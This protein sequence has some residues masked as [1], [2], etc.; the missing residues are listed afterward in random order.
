MEGISVKKT[1]FKYICHDFLCNR[2]SGGVV[3]TLERLERKIS[4]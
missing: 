2:N 3:L 4:R 1:I